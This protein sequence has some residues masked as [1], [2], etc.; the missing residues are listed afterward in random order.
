M[1]QEA[2]VPAGLWG[3]IQKMIDDSIARYARSGALQNSAIT[4][5]AGLTIRDGGVL[6]AQYPSDKGGGDAVY[7]GPLYSATDGSY[8]GTGFLVQ[9]T[10]GND[11]ATFRTDVGYGSTMQ[12]IYDSGQRIIFGNDA[13]SGQG[14]ARPYIPGV[15]YPA[16]YQDMTVGT[17]ATTWDTLWQGTHYK[18]HPRLTVG[19]SATMDTS[20][21]AGQLRVL[22][23]GVQLDT[24][25][26]V[27]F[28]IQN[29]SFTG[30]VAGEHESSLL[31]QV[32]AQVV[33]GGGSCKAVPYSD[34]GI[35]S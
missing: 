1:A 8:V 26:S 33:S 20:G 18:Q 2:A 35:Q 23:N 32:Q 15:L 10:N 22:V 9:D 14:L 3:R 29:Y 31:V 6:R 7:V 34:Y 19:V 24:T 30:A 5:G 25:K 13:A 21:A 28:Q 27:A 4:G 12:N 16:R 11:L 17:N